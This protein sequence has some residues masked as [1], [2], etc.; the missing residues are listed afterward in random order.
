MRRIEDNKDYVI[1]SSPRVGNRSSVLWG[2]TEKSPKHSSKVCPRRE[3]EPQ[4]FYT[5]LDHHWL[6]LAPESINYLELQPYVCERSGSL[7]CLRKILGTEMQIFVVRRGWSVASSK[8]R[9][10]WER[11]CSVCYTNRGEVLFLSGC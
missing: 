7:Q 1:K 2:S 6:R 10:I 3:E 4:G 9:R 8:V 11:Q 5:T